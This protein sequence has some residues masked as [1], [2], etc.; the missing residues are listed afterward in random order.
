[1]RFSVRVIDGGYAFRIKSNMNFSKSK[2]L[3]ASLGVIAYCIGILS[4]PYAKLAV[5]RYVFGKTDVSLPY[6]KTTDSNGSLGDLARFDE[7]Y[8]ILQDNYFGFDSVSGNDLESGMIKG[9]ID[10]LGDRHSA[11]FDIDETKK[12]NE[13][14][15]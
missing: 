10:S 14:L 11:Y 7:A 6:A 3:L 1:M 2:R 15:S 8:R 13:A 4:A 5:D 9:M 12:F